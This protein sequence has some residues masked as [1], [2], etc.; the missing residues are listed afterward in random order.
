MFHVTIQIFMFL[1]CQN[2]LIKNTPIEMGGQ[3]SPPNKRFNDSS[4]LYMPY[5]DWD[6]QVS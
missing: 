1:R 2:H 4:N 5:M 3:E 6:Q